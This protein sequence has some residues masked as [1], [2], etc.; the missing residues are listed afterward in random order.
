MIIDKL[1]TIITTFRRLWRHSQSG[2]Y[3]NPGNWGS[4]HGNKPSS[5]TTMGKRMWLNHKSRILYI[6]GWSRNSVIGTVTRLS[7]RYLGVKISV[8]SR[9]LFSSPV[10]T[11][12]LQGPTILLL[13]VNRNSIPVVNW[14]DLDVDRSPPSSSEVKNEWSYTF[15]PLYAL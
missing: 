15:T 4:D 9:R 3:Y 5:F 2:F 12:R 7:A 1:F 6:R 10:C 11:E 14:S 8:E 13:N